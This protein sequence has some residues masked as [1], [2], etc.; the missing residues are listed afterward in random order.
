MKTNLL[1][2]ATAVIRGRQLMRLP[3]L[4]EAL[5]GISRSTVYDR[6]QRDPDFPKPIPLGRQVPTA[7]GGGRTRSTM[8]AWRADEVD[9][10]ISARTAERDEAL[11]FAVSR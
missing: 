11:E 10:Y 6:L 4:Q 8:V 5:G 9:A 3:A 2:D 7:V 1:N